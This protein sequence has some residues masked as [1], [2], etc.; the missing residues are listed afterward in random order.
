MGHEYIIFKYFILATLLNIP[1]IMTCKFYIFRG[2][3][4]FVTRALTCLA[5]ARRKLACISL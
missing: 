1:M 5:H 3:I 4:G 2:L